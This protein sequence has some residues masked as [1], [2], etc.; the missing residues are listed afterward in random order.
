MAPFQSLQ[1][2]LLKRK[3][4]HTENSIAHIFFLPNT[5]D[6]WVFILIIRSDRYSDISAKNSD[7]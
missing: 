4:N 7:R 2:Y 3:N 1:N 5:Y 6:I